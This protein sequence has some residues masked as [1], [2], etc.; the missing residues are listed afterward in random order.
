VSKGS[1]LRG[2]CVFVGPTLNVTGAKRYADVVVRPPAAMGDVYKAIEQGFEIVAIIDGYFEQRAAVWHKEILW[3]LSRGIR[4]LGS[5]SM[6]ALRAAELEPFGMEGIGRVFHAFRDRRL[7]DDDEVAV[8]H[9]PAELGYILL[10]EAMV[11]IRFT[12]DKAR[13]T[14]I[15][16]D[17]EVEILTIGTKSL[18]FPDRNYRSLCE[19]GRLRGISAPTLL[20]FAEWLKTERIEQKKLDAIALLQFIQLPPSEIRQKMNFD[21]QHTAMWQRLVE[22]CENKENYSP[23]SAHI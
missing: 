14:G 20:I 12:M 8:R 3:G 21:F 9:G 15:L 16:S 6:G 17:I 2:A 5:S 23:I 7:I 19:V 11:D 18:H 4:I 22:I 13:Q 10:S 1:P